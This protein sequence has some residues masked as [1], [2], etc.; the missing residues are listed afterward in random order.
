VTIPPEERDKDLFEKLKPEWP[1]ILAWAAAGCT[2]WQKQGLNPPAVIRNATNDYLAAEDAFKQWIE[3]CCLVGRDKWGVG[4]TLWNSWKEWAER[5][6]ERPGS[7]KSFAS[8]MAAH[9][10]ANSKS[11]EVRG[12]D[13]I[14]LKPGINPD[15]KKSGINLNPDD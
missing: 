11:Q 9:G 12:Y 8:A 7:R 13:D 14:M 2:E 5:N 3:E 6:N 1:G 10:H 4:A 15:L